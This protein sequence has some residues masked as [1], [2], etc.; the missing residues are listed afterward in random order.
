MYP[1][2]KNALIELA[3]LGPHM[4]RSVGERDQLVRLA[5]QGYVDVELGPPTKFTLTAKGRALVEG[6]KPAPKAK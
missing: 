4:P 1:L 3:T 6:K 5:R 2:D